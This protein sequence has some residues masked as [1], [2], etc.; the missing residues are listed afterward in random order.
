MHLPALQT[1]PPA[2]LN[3]KNGVPYDRKTRMT[4]VELPIDV[5]LSVTGLG[6]LALSDVDSSVCTASCRWRSRRAVDTGV[7][8]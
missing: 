2:D 6:Y 7:D 5:S 3:E 1:A 4:V 8:T